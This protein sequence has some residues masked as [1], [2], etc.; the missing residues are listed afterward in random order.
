LPGKGALSASVLCEIREQ[1]VIVIGELINATRKSVNGIMVNRDVAGLLEL[2]RRQIAA[3]ADYL[4]VNAATG[5]SGDSEP[6]AME[7]AV[8]TILREMDVA[9][10]IDSASPEVMSAAL[11]T[12]MK[13]APILNSVNAEP[14]RLEAILPLAKGSGAS[15]ICLAMG[16]GGISEK[17]SERLAMCRAIYDRAMA[18]GIEPE[19]LFFDPLIMTVATSPEQGRVTIETLR[20]IKA[21]LPGAKTAR[22]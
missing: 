11:K 9:L 3:G 6:A 18:L 19:R 12:G 1:V 13:K 21:E 22:C 16:K 5:A 2:A 7:W 15:L 17:A 10:S 20:R 14:E 4:D 8:T